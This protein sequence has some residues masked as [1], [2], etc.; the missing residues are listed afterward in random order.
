MKAVDAETTA[1]TKKGAIL[2]AVNVSDFMN[3]LK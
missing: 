2:F 3:F 1:A